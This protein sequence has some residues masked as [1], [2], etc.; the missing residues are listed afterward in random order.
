MQLQLNTGNILNLSSVPTT[1]NVF[2]NLSG[3]GTLTIGPFSIQKK[4]PKSYLSILINLGLT[5]TFDPQEF[6]NTITLKIIRNNLTTAPILENNFS[7]SPD[8]PNFNIYTQ[9]LDKNSPPGTNISGS[10]VEYLIEIEYSLL[11]NIIASIN[12]N[13]ISFTEESHVSKISPQ[14]LII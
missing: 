10:P 2:E 13:S 8:E 11:P 5:L 1:T 6:F 9:Y 7:I 4:S 3:S 12:I 14:I